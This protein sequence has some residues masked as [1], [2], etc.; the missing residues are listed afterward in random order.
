MRGTDPATPSEALVI[1]MA[2][3]VFFGSLFRTA[4]HRELTDIDSVAAQFLIGRS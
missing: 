2:I 3:R 4:L 1:R